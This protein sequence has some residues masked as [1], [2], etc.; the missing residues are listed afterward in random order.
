MATTPDRH[1][2]GH[3]DDPAGLA[4]L[5]VGGIEP[6][7]GVGLAGERAT[8]EGLDLGIERGADAAHLALADA[9]DAEGLDEVLHAAGRDAQDVGLADDR[10]ERPGVKFKD[11]DLI[12]IPLRVT[13]GP[14]ALARGAVELKGRREASAREIP[15]DGAV[16]QLTALVREGGV[17]A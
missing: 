17:P 14:K 4:D 1:E 6:Q 5:D 13:V 10:E 9:G 11:A 8:A 15:L 2:R 7:V 16:A 3:G 12:G